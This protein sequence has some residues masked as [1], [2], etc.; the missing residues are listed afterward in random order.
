MDLLAN[1]IHQSYI[2]FIS[3]YQTY[4]TGLYK[5][6][7]ETHNNK[8]WKMENVMKSFQ[9]ITLQILLY[10]ECNHMDINLPAIKDKLI[11]NSFISYRKKGSCFMF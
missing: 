2:H 3:E 10:I 7:S 9:Q 1:P 8:K 4:K 6:L 5:I 11:W